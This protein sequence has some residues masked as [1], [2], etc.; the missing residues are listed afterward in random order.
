MNLNKTADTLRAIADVMTESGGVFINP[1]DFETIGNFAKRHDLT[2]PAVAYRVRENHYDPN[3]L[4]IIDD[5][6]FIKKTA[7]SRNE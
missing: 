5:K 6:I 1:K 3:D 4:L 7:K 2:V